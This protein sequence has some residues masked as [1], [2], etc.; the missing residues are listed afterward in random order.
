[1]TAGLAAA[2]AL[3]VWRRRN[4]PLWPVP[5]LFSLIVIAELALK[6]VLPHEGPPHHASR[7]FW[8]LPTL[9]TPNSFPSGH[10]ARVT[11]LALVTSAVWPWRAVR[12][13]AAAVVVITLW[14]RVYI[15]DHWL[16]DALGGLLLGAAVGVIGFAEITRA[17]ADR[18]SAAV[19]T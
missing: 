17:R 7:S 8:D 11:F 19:R 15:G 18:R 3:F 9:G 6:L 13:A 5:L 16:S 4:V 1:L 14:A 2:V 12:V 10:V